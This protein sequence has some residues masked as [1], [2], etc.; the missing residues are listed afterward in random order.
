[1]NARL[2]LL[3]I[4]VAPSLA[5]AQVDEW[6]T[7]PADEQSPPAPVEREAPSAQS[8]TGTDR[9]SPS[10]LGNAWNSPRNRRVS[11]GLVGSSGL[12]RTSN[13][14][15]GATGLVRVGVIGEYFAHENFP[16]GDAS[17]VRTGGSFIVA[18]TPLAWLEAY[19]A[20]GAAANTNS[21]SSPTL[22]QALGDMTVGA[23]LTREWLPGLH[24]GIDLRG[25]SFSSVGRQDVS[26]YAWGFAPRLVLTYDAR[27]RV[28]RVPVL[29]H[30][31][32]G[33]HLDTTAG[34][35]GGRP[36][37]ASEEFAYNVNRYHRL[38]AGA[39]LELPIAVVAP[40]LEYAVAVPLGVPNGRLP[41]PAGGSA[42]V[43]YN[44]AMSQTF[45]A[46]ARV[47]ALK[48][49]TF[50]VGMEFGLATAV[51]LGVPATP[52]WNLFVGAAF[53]I[54][55]L[56]RELRVVEK[57]RERPKPPL[58]R[59]EGVVV[60]ARS[61]EPIAG[62]IVAMVGSSAPPVASDAPGGRF[63]THDVPPGKVMLRAEKAGYTLLTRE[64]ML[65]PG[66]IANVQFSLEPHTQL[67]RFL[68]SVM[69]GEK[70]KQALTAELKLRGPV[71]QSVQL[72]AGAAEPSRVEVPPGRYQINV[73]APE[74]LAQT[75]E[76]DLAGNA[77]MKLAFN[78]EREPSK[79]L[80][81]VKGDKINVLQQVHF[82]YARAAILP[83]SHGLL[84]QVVD[85]I[86]KNDIKRVRVEG[87]SDNRG[88]KKINHTLS[89][90]RARAVAAY[91]VKLGIDPSRVETFGHGDSRPLAPNLSAR[92]REMNR[93][94]EFVIVER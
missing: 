42:T 66:K 58:S 89:E 54:D 83:D 22:I 25:Q 77:E 51:G 53:S 91:L 84:N 28:P 78:L 15:L 14:A 8:T 5:L 47:T 38:L 82:A 68:V 20:Y 24:A 19:L 72:A 36:L 26:R 56:Q 49:V 43:A 86:V 30:L 59:V 9:Q 6:S 32:G 46:G 63:L 76:I 10:T 41:S 65:E 40:Y 61:H 73:L 69:G 1:M 3:T 71:N 90:D 33:I 74:H 18:Y 44:E 45:G 79:K 55:P 80:V 94:V 23:K 34:L 88:S 29:V 12:V 4:L 13:A 57:P 70:K 21:S 37:T 16:V 50:T 11:P 2:S 62:A 27:Q 64:V 31:N 7:F 92:G 60:D 81:V 67:A 39:A 52:P 93:R 17:N 87:H 85:A 35:V 48:D 75:R